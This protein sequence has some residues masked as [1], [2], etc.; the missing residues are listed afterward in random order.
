MEDGDD[1]DDHGDLRGIP[2]QTERLTQYS[3]Y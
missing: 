2:F 3:A 1:D